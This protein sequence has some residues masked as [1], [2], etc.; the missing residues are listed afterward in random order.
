MPEFAPSSARSP[1]DDALRAAAGERAHDGCAAADVAAVADDDALRDASLDHRGA[2]RAGVEVH[3]ALVHDGG[4]G[5]EVRAE[6]HARG[7]GDAHARS[8]VT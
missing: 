7:I 6:P 3:E 1:I 5:G 2:E 4:A 8:G